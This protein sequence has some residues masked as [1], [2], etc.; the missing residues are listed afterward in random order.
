VCYLSK[1]CRLNEG[2]MILTGTGA[3]VGIV[4]R[5][6]IVETSM[7]WGNGSEVQMK[8]PVL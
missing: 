6:D 3:G 4:K 7:Q 5:G 1:H 8:T 2:D